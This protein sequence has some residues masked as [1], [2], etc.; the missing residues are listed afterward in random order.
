M[1]PSHFSKDTQ[2]FLRLLAKE[3]VKYVIVGGEAVISFIAAM[4]DSPEM[5]IFSMNVQKRMH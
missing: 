3:E 2:E 4:P 1:E 5:L